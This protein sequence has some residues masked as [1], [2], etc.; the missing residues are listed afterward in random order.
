MASSVQPTVPSSTTPTTTNTHQNQIPAVSNLP[1]QPIYPSS[2]ANNTNF[3]SKKR[4]LDHLYLLQSSPYFKMRT[5]LTELR[6]LFLEVLRVPDFQSSEAVGRIQE[7]MKIMVDLCREQQ[8][9]EKVPVSSGASWVQKPADQ[10]RRFPVGSNLEKPTQGINKISGTY[11]VG[12]SAFGWNFITFHG[13]KPEYYGRTKEA[14]R[15]G[16]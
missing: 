5:I 10:E 16:K 6:P 11:I 9:A 14:F 13:T 2:L 7:K 3:N 1:P 4:P 15:A 8:K 12:G